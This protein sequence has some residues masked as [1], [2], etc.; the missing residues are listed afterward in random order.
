MSWTPTESEVS[1]QSISTDPV[2]GPVLTTLGSFNNSHPSAYG[3]NNHQGVE[4]RQHVT[5]HQVSLPIAESTTHA[6]NAPVFGR[7]EH[8]ISVTSASHPQPFALS[9]MFL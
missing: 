9:G 4:K 2:A 1:R 5:E 3:P 6:L 8:S 7:T